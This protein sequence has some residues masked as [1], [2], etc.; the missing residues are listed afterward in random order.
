MDSL[1]FQKVK[2]VKSDKNKENAN[3]SGF[4]LWVRIGEEEGKLE[5]R[6]PLVIALIISIF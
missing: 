6:F 5:W 3:S 4:Y 2:S 1:L